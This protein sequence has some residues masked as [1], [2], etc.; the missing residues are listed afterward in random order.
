MNR[1]QKIAWW[2]VIS[3]AVA[4]VAGIIVVSLLSHSL[5]LSKTLSYGVATVCM[6]GPL[7]G[8]GLLFTK[9]RQR[10]GHP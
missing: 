5:S 7:S 9:K 6:A 8:L 1:T 2:C 4:S 3:A 10:P